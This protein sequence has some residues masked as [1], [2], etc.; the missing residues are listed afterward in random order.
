MHA[1]QVRP[2]HLVITIDASEADW[3]LWTNIER[4]DTQQVTIAPNVHRTQTSTCALSR[5]VL[6]LAQTPAQPPTV[7]SIA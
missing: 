7:H 1:C 4:F 6:G 2:W 5:L 3:H